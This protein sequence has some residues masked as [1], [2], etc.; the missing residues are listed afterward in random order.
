MWNSQRFC[1]SIVF[2][3]GDFTLVSEIIQKSQKTILYEWDWSMWYVGLRK[4]TN[5]V[6]TSS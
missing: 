6:L 1:P 5:I 2:V 3:I 4:K